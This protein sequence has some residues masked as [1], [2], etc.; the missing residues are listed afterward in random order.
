MSFSS[1]AFSKSH[2]CV[3]F[4]INLSSQLSNIF[5]K[6]HKYQ[7]KTLC[8]LQRDFYKFL[9]T[10]EKIVKFSIKIVLNIYLWN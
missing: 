9:L 8:I 4:E 10:F 3:F 5:T 6:I 2:K 7:Q 1:F